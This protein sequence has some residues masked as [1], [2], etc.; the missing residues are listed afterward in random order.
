[1]YIIIGILIVGSIVIIFYFN[2]RPVSWIVIN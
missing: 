2:K 1:M